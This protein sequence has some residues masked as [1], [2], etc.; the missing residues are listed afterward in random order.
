MR[1]RKV[2]QRGAIAA[3]G[4]LALGLIFLTAF[5][6][7]PFEGSLADMRDVVPREV[8]FFLRKTDLAD[9]FTEFPEPRFW[10]ELARSDAWQELRGGPLMRELDRGGELSQAVERL[11]GVVTDLREQSGGWVDLL[12]DVIGTELEIAGIFRGS[13]PE[14]A[15][16]CIYTRVSWKVKLAW[17]LAGY[18][19]VMDRVRR[20]GLTMQWSD[21]VLTL[22]GGRLA[23][24][25]FAARFLDCLMISNDEPLLRESLAL[26]RGEGEPFG[27]S[28]SYRDGVV[29][30]LRDWAEM[31]GVRPNALEFY[32]R[33][34][35]YLSLV[36]WDDG[37]PDPSHPDS[38]NERVLASFVNL[39]TWLFLTGAL[40]FEPGSLSVLADVE[41]NQNRHTP[42]QAKFF[43]AEPQARSE[44]LDP[45]LTLVPADACAAAA[46]RMPAGDFLREMYRALDR[47]EQDLVN[48]ALRKTGKYDSAFDLIAKI[49]P[50]LL[51]RTGFVFRKN[52][53]DPEIKVANPS[54]MPQVAWVFWLRQGG[55]R[56]VQEF[57]EILKD[58]YTAF[59]FTGAWKLP[60][61]VGGPEGDATL[62]FTNP[63]I[64]GTGEIA[65]LVYERFFAL[66]NSGPLIT[67]MFQAR[68]GRRPSITSRPDFEELSAELPPA[69]NGF[70]FLQ[71][72]ELARVLRD[73]EDAILSIS[74]TPDPEWM[75]ENRPR[76]RSEVFLQKYRPRGYA[77]V[78][79]MPREVK[80]QFE[81]DVDARLDRMWEEARPRFAAGSLDSIRQALALT[82]LFTSAYLQ[83]QLEPRHLRLG[84]R[85]LLGFR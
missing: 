23:A 56:T 4:L 3:A 25:I 41:I 5:V 72:D 40:V 13:R 32:L 53:P 65:T 26:A 29:R 45:F 9:D 16:V 15:A 42:F 19:F 68:L 27:V 60:I 1:M 24:P 82:R 85:V 47:E 14:E 34:N 8:D 84:G 46:L 44:W 2:L 75:L 79:S 10:E 31:A 22:S 12:D 71:A 37:W 73:Y 83:V 33:P 61:G 50:A 30:R 51:P 55:E 11:R 48:D 43:R 20:Q 35:R 17:G 70:V 49:E 18:G 21:G 7:N 54:P 76:A 38:M 64:P 28:A 57:L 69:V 66:S 74:A 59:G 36:S 52:T 67:H 58:F 81:R 39:E 78:A 77:T 63:Q 6:F 80:L 62:E